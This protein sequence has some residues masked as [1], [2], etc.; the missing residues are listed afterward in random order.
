MFQ[1]GRTAACHPSPRSPS[2]ADKF[3]GYCFTVNDCESTNVSADSAGR[4]MSLLP[5]KR[6]R[7]LPRQPP[8]ARS[9]RSAFSTTSESADDSAE[10]RAS[11][12]NY[13]RTLAFA[14]SRKCTD[15]NLNWKVDTFECDRIEA[16]LKFR[17]AGEFAERLGVGHGATHCCTLRNSAAPPTRT[18]LAKHCPRTFALPG[19]ASNRSPTQTHGNRGTGRHNQRLLLH[20]FHGRHCGGRFVGIL[21]GCHCPV[22]RRCGQERRSQPRPGHRWRFTG[23]SDDP[24]SAK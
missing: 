4:T 3:D 13:R 8:A 16:N 23:T 11:A 1:Q 2:V 7:L 21:I 19:L 6:S 5:V 18:S 10:S 14:F 20:F 24:D 17:A 9:D 22:A 15:G 12:G